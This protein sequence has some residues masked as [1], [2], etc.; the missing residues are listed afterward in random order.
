[1][2]GRT[3]ALLGGAATVV[4]LVAVIL[5]LWAFTSPKKPTAPTITFSPQQ[6]SQQALKDGN[7]ALSKE[8]T[9]TAI[10]LF[11]SAIT[12]DPSNTAAKVALENAK[13]GKPSTTTDT[14]GSTTTT[15][16]TTTTVAPSGVWETDLDV[17]KLLPKAYPDYLIGSVDKAGSVAVVA[18]NPSKRGATVT[19][20][21]W[22]VLDQGTDAKAANFIT[23]TSKTQYGHDASTVRVND[24]D[25]YFGTD[26]R[27][28]A[29]VAFTRGRYVFE[30][31]IA[32]SQAPLKEK[33]FVQKAAAAFAT[34][35]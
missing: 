30:L 27:Q 20:I 2:S 6:R 26:G 28:L 19:S 17:A 21:T 32:S 23:K 1:M 16:P 24:V 31:L 25:A 12:I 13:S 11:Q 29:T 34:A 33:A 18:A 5:G 8:Q 4:V 35:P 9:G 7:D 15:K 22:T 10:E 3:K 14:G